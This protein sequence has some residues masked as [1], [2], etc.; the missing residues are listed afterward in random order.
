[1]IGFAIAVAGPVA[2]LWL[3]SVLASRG[4][5]PPGPAQAPLVALLALPTLVRWYGRPFPEQLLALLVSIVGWGGPLLADDWMVL[6][7]SGLVGAAWGLWLGVKATPAATPAGSEAAGGNVPARVTSSRKPVP[8][9]HTLRT[10][11]G[12][13]DLG[14]RLALRCPTCGA[15]VLAAVYHQM[16]HC[17]YCDSSHMV[18]SAAQRLVTV[19]PDIVTDENAVRD[20]V[21]RYLQHLRYERRYDQMVRPLVER[22]ENAREGGELGS[23][24]A[25]PRPDPIADAAEAVV[26]KEA[27][28]YAAHARTRVRI[29]RWD[30]FLAPYW[31][32]SG[33]LY[34]VAFGRDQQ[35]EKKMEFA[36][37]TLESSLPAS[38]TPLPE[39]GKLSYLRAL[40]PLLGAPEASLPVLPADRPASELDERVKQLSQRR[41]ELGITTIA[42]T[43]TL[44]AEVDALVYRPWHAVSGQVEGETFALLI[45]GGA[46]GVEGTPPQLAAPPQPLHEAGSEGAPSLTP[47]RCPECGADL[48]YDPDAVAHLCMNCYRL[49]GM[50]GPKWHVVP[51]LREEPAAKSLILPFWRFPFRL[52]T[53]DGDLITDLPHLTDGIDGTFDQIGNAPAT[54]QFFYVPAFRTRVGRSGVRLYRRLWP[55]IQGWARPL[56]PER[57]SPASPPQRIVAVTLPAGEARVFARVY[58]ALAFTRRDLARAELRGVRETLL[59]AKLE[60]EPDLVFLNLAAELVEPFLAVIGRSTPEAVARLEGRAS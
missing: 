60:G 51:Y 14:F 13:G 20:A 12:E 4:S 52:R 19:I 9:L 25:P 16:A 37:S 23:F 18:V 26:Q 41:V 31:H 10:Q 1:M 55:A 57:F 29:D 6:V 8:A 40:R 56:T 7:A 17:T 45:E 35:G 36:V 53:L 28:A 24:G 49:V 44:V 48:G 5:S 58:L 39:M 34:Q 15:E 27:E 22:S 30:R 50:R 59:G 38:A 43:A 33:T 21:V 32:R 46:G 2:L 3:G 11:E 47:S 54:Q 42:R